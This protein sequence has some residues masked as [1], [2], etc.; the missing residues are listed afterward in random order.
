MQLLNNRQWGKGLQG[1]GHKLVGILLATIGF[2]W[3]ANKAG[4]IPVSEG[5]SV[6]FWPLV[7]IG[8]GLSILLSSR[9]GRA[10]DNQ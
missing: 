6:I 3:L 1:N 5:G 10:K 9:R 4:W 7:T 8:L 2:F